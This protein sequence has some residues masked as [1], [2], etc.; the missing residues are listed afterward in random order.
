MIAPH[1][2]SQAALDAGVPPR[3]V[4]WQGHSRRRYLFTRT[5][6]QGLKDFE[7]G[8]V[9][10]VE[11]GEVVWTGEVAEASRL[12]KAGMLDRAASTSTCSRAAWPSAGWLSK[13]LSRIGEPTA[14]WQREFLPQT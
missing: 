10:V 13:I 9:L 12:R 4:Y 5:S 11:G 2:L 14:G 1:S 8:V 3:F 7:D 6:F